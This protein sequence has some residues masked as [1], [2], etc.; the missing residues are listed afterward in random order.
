MNGFEV[1][2]RLGQQD[3]P[4]L[5]VSLAMGSLA[6]MDG[7][8][9]KV[10]DNV[11]SEWLQDLSE[12]S[13]AADYE[14]W[15]EHRWQKTIGRAVQGPVEAKTRLLVGA[16][17][18]SAVDVGLRVHHTWGVPFIPGSSLKGLLSHWLDTVYGPSAENDANHP[19]DPT[20]PEPDRAKFR[21]P[22]T[23]G[24][25]AHGAGEIQRILFGSPDIDEDV[26][27][28]R[29]WGRLE[30][31]SGMTGCRGKI[32]I[33][34][35]LF[36]PGSANNKPFL[37]DVLTV[38]HADYYQGKGRAND[39]ESPN[40]V[41]FLSVRPGAQFLLAVE[42]APGEPTTYEPWVDFAQGLLLEALAD[43]GIGSKTA[44]GYGRLVKIGRHDR[45][46]KPADEKRGELASWLMANVDG[47]WRTLETNGADALVAMIALQH[48]NALQAATGE[49]RKQRLQAI[50]SFI[51]ND[52]KVGT[53][54]A[55]KKQRDAI[56][57]SL[58]K[59]FPER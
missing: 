44:A 10:P 17:D 48:G 4:G 37:A 52:L 43:W 49:I 30:L 34:D 5:H 8:T 57:E 29:D 25:H 28:L 16:G 36:V 2:M 1:G 46:E 21:R 14:S 18:P 27:P 20:H 3:R 38:H 39:Y 26:K 24:T 13:V 42:L 58:E 54:Q 53:R 31:T 7:V 33:H 55:S 41:G 50:N 9:G 19:W 12:I 23:A 59:A 32:V 6:P 47:L 15:F 45:R 40:P 22:H 11:R 56:R 51:K 35:A